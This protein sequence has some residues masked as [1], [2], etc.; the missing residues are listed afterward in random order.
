VIPKA[1]SQKNQLA[2]LEALTFRLTD[3]EVKEVTK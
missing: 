2:N 3:E 1:E